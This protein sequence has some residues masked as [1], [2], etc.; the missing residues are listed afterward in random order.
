MRTD[1]MNRTTAIRT[2]S[3]DAPQ[4]RR[5]A[6]VFLCVL[7]AVSGLTGQ[8][9]QPRPEP[10]HIPAP[11]IREAPAPNR[12]GESSEQFRGMH[13]P[14]WMESHANLSLSEQQQSL[15]REPGF[16]RLNPQVQQHIREQLTRLNH[17]SPQQRARAFARTEAMER[18]APEQRQ[19]VRSAMETLGAL[20]DGRRQLVAREFRAL[21]YMPP[22]QRDVFMNSPQ[23]RAMFSDHERVTMEGLFQVEP[24]LPPPSAQPQPSPVQAVPYPPR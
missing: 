8:A 15:E 4:K 3:S 9:Q 12:S 10:G 23:M 1:A 16:N 18:L 5:V 24:L 17:M 11:I 7:G 13:L 20:P 2:A 14:Q 19:Q 21:R 6:L 22:A